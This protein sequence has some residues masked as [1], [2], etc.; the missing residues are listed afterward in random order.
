MIDKKNCNEDMPDISKENLSLGEFLAEN[1]LDDYQLCIV[2]KQRYVRENDWGGCF[3]GYVGEFMKDTSEL[4]E[5]FRE[6]KNFDFEFVDY[7]TLVITIFDF[8]L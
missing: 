2:I 1:H 6:H 3:N 5:S 7:K 8:Y 4:C